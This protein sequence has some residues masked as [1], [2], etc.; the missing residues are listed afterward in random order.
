M[1]EKAKAAKQLFFQRNSIALAKRMKHYPKICYKRSK[2]IDK[3]ILGLKEIVE[4]RECD[5]INKAFITLFKDLIALTT[6]LNREYLYCAVIQKRLIH[7]LNNIIKE[8]TS[9]VK[10]LDKS[11]LAVEDLKNVFPVLNK[12]ILKFEDAIA[13]IENMITTQ[14]EEARHLRKEHQTFKEKNGVFVTEK[15]NLHILRDK[16]I[17]LKQKL[18]LEKFEE[19]EIKNIPHE[20]KLALKQE[21]NTKKVVEVLQK[22]T[23]MIDKESKTIA[24]EIKDIQTIQD[25]SVKAYFEALDDV[26]NVTRYFNWL[27]NFNDPAPYPHEF[28]KEIEKMY[29]KLKEAITEDEKF[30]YYVERFLLGKAKDLKPNSMDLKKIM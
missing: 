27:K 21:K 11:E 20:L 4:T 17:E 9:M 14:M 12:E 29:E 15:K 6:L 7:N 2:K 22:L 23:Q 30:E 10:T 1:G 28:I 18:K 24:L 5:L 3:Q 16:A 13:F 19:K 26:N 25:L 8:I